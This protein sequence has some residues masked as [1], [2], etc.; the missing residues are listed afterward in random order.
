MPHTLAS[1]RNRDGPS[2]AVKFQPCQGR[3]GPLTP[4]MARYGI[5]AVARSR[6]AFEDAA[7]LVRTDFAGSV[8]VTTPRQSL[9]VRLLNAEDSA[10][11]E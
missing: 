4:D 3:P 10:T 8:H 6:A 11:Q 5:A 7:L 2:V 9:L 1:N